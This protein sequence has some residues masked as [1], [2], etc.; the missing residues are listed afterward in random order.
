MTD[1]EPYLEQI[2]TRFAHP[3]K[4]AAFRGFS[5]TVQFTFSDL[6]RDFTIHV[7]EDGLATL[8]D[9]PVS[10][11]DVQVITS[12]DTL[13]GILDGKINPIQ[14]YL[15]RQL[16]VSGQMGDLLKLQQLL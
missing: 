9:H 12:S 8:M 11:P 14:A 16:K 3:E 1:I 2:C 5:K 10:Q 6:G 4:H 7:H 15:T 13:A